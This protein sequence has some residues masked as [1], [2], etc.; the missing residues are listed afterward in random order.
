MSEG[1]LPDPVSP[2]SA[3]AGGE[4]LET[5]ARRN[6]ELAILNALS[7]ALNRSLDLRGLDLAARAAPARRGVREGEPGDGPPRRCP[8]QGVP[9]GVPTGSAA[10]ATW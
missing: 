3:P 7:Q 10:R 6:R 8:A 9:T 4:M 2:R 5:L 1:E